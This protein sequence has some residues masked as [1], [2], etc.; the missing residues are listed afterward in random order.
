MIDLG[1]IA[2]INEAVEQWRES[3][4]SNLPDVAHDEQ[5]GMR[6]RRLVWE[7]IAEELDEIKTVLISPD[8]E[9][10]KFPWSTLPGS[11]P[12]SYLI[13]DG[14]NIVLIPVPQMLPELLD[15]D[16]KAVVL[17]D[18]RNSTDGDETTMLLVGD[19]DYGAAANQTMDTAAETLFAGVNPRPTVRGTQGMGF[20]ELP[21]TAQEIAEV[22]KLFQERFSKGQMLELTKTNATAERGA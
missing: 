10:A 12:D 7:P 17:H 18:A 3:Y 14:I 20:S 4:G 6:L 1:L 8:G 15:A 11:K 13:E 9:V 21:G 5:P 16:F 19:V 22:K 2:P